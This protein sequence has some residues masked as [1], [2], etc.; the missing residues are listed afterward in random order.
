ML[1]ELVSEGFEARCVGV[2]RKK[3]IK[4]TDEAKGGY[5]RAAGG[6]EEMERFE[7]LGG[8]EVCRM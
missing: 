5:S 4:N 6:G 2:R 1:K 7:E 8:E 3:I